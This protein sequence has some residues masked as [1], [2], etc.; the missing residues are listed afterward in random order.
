MGWMQDVHSSIE[1]IVSSEMPAAGSPV[2]IIF[3]NTPISLAGY[4]VRCR[5]LLGDSQQETLGRTSQVHSAA[6]VLFL[7]VFFPAHVGDGPL[8]TF[9][10]DLAT[11]FRSRVLTQPHVEF[12]S[13]SI[14]PQEADGGFSMRTVKVTFW[15]E[16]SFSV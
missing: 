13:P 10:D 8:L 15:T 7:N 2:T 4:Y 12:E 1:T 5:I 6:G 11:V 3:D 16:A 14:G 9:C